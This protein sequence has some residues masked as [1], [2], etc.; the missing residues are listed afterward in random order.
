MVAGQSIQIRTYKSKLA[1]V[2]HEE[3]RREREMGE[4]N[5]IQL[6]SFL[7]M[8]LQTQGVGGTE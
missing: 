4:S 1:I 7:R 3:K 5:L 8:I 6:F 2:L